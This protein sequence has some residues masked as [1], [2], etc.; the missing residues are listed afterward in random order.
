MKK[1]IKVKKI[2]GIKPPLKT[3]LLSRLATE[4]GRV[5]ED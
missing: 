3:I 5:D 1:L 2:K 4:S